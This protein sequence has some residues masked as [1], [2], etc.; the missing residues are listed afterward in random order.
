MRQS[1]GKRKLPR[2]LI[3]IICGAALGIYLLVSGS[4]SA[5]TTAS[6]VVPDA[7]RVAYE[8]TGKYIGEMEVRAQEL[9]D[10]ITGVAGSKVCVTT[11]G[12][13]EYVYATKSTLKENSS[14][15]EELNK[16]TSRDIVLFSDGKNGQYPIFIRS[17]T[18]AVK[19][20]AVVC[21]NGSGGQ[22]QA[23]IVQCM[24]TLFDV[25]YNK[26]YVY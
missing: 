12:S 5:K 4:M 14:G 1:E 16:D 21:P 6:A 9:V 17:V 15:A 20:I 22:S 2:N 3:F 18:P 7:P 8:D 10:A 23:Q 11:S 13:G 19:G 24:A 25:P 26:I